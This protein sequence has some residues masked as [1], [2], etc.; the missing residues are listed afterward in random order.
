MSSNWSVYII[1]GSD[2]RF[3]TGITTDVKRRWSE[4]CEANK[5]NGETGKKK[6]N[7]GAK[8]FRGR[9]PKE[10]VFYEP[11]HDRSSATKREIAI[12]KLSRNDKKI[13]I[14][15][16]DNQLPALDWE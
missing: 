1:L 9:S 11:G 12:K 10:L 16:T 13:L 14:A 3:Y 7:K 8:Y 2:D 15:S 6:T 4:H 5:K